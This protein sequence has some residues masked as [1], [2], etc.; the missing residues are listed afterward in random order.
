LLRRARLV[1]IGPRG[2]GQQPSA[3]TMAAQNPGKIPAK[4]AS[5]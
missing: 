1:V 4:N 3:E 2:S 5:L